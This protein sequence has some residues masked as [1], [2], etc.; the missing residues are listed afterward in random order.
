M[1]VQ[2]TPFA[3]GDYQ[4]NCHVVTSGDDCWVVDCGYSPEELIQYLQTN[5]LQP[6]AILLT[7]CH[8]DHIAGLDQ[9][10]T[11]IGATP[12][13]CHSSESEW[14]MKPNVEFIRARREANNSRTAKLVSSRQG[15]QLHLA[16]Q[17]GKFSTHQVIALGAFALFMSNLDKQ[18]SGTLCL[19]EVLDGT[20]SQQAMLRI[21]GIPFRKS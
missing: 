14:N 19:L 10:T 7:H 6:S 17:F 9:L 15:I 2:I 1:P 11:A 4:T 13:L 20:I 18:L 16:I 12:V 8:A 21:Y 5:N 3:L